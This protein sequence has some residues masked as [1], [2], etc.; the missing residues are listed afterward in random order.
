MHLVMKKEGAPAIA[1]TMGTDYQD[2]MNRVNDNQERSPRKL[3][4]VIRIMDES[5]N[6]EP[7][8]DWLND[9]YGYLCVKRPRAELTK[10]S[11][12]EL[13]AKVAKEMGELSA[14]LLEAT[15]D[16]VIDFNEFIGLQKEIDD[17]MRITQVLNL[18]IKQTAEQKMTGVL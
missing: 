7:F 10:E 8:L 4:L 12:F 6:P 15:Q 9:R 1:I 18:A 3:E 11:L 17:L 5:G 16:G 13:M 2:M 14:A